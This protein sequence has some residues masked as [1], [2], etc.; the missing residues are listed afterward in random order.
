MSDWF[1]ILV[2][3]IKKF[4]GKMSYDDY[5]YVNYSYTGDLYNKSDKWGL[6]NLVFAVKILYITGLMDE[7]FLKEK[8]NLIN[9][10]TKFTHKNEIY[11]PII[12]GY[13]I[14][15]IFKIIL[16]RYPVEN[17]ILIRDIRRAETRQSYAA[18]HL[19]NHKP[20]QPYTLIPYSVDEVITFLESF[21][22][23]LPWGAG[24]HASHLI[25]FLWYNANILNYKKNEAEASIKAC[26]EWL[27]K[28]Q[29]AD[30][31]CW[32]VGNSV[33]LSQ[34]I[35]GAMKVFTGYHAAHIYDIPYPRKIIDTALAGINDFEACSNF[36]IV[37][38]LYGATRIE[39]EY[40][41]NEIQDF[42]LK[43]LDIYKEYYWPDLGGFSFHKGRAN[44]IYYGK[45]ITSGKSEPDIH[46]TIMFVWGIAIINKILNLGLDWKIPLN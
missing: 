12:S 9:H 4:L 15:D 44:D 24:S 26:V 7:L 21:D 41:K 14:N 6:A 5:S 11:D 25:F 34:K 16:G 37:Y 43:R 23:S 36:N 38:V 29:S 39:T 46:G 8:I 19:L 40:R 27:S 32:Y 17:K 3:G 18:L 30:D 10:I 45:K 2:P 13:Q 35:N 31:G 28:I 33:S 1:K 22:W 20:R 42:L